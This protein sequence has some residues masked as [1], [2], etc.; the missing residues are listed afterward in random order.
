MR[1]RLQ[2]AIS[3]SLA[4]AF[5]TGCDDPTS[6][7]QVSTIDAAVRATT[8]R[9]LTATPASEARI[10][11][12]WVDEET[13]ETGWET[14]RSSTG[15]SGTF[16]RIASLG[17]NVTAYTD[18]GLTAATDYCYKVRP[19]RS[20]KGKTTYLA[21]SSVVCS[22]TFALPA[23]SSIA[24]VPRSLEEPAW[25]SVI[26]VAW[27]DGSSSEEGFRI[28]RSGAAAGPWTIVA[29]VGANINSYA[30]ST[31]QLEQLTCYRVRAF[32]TTTGESASSPASCTAAPRRP[33]NIVARALDAAS[34][35]VTWSDSSVVEDGYEVERALADGVWSLIAGLA[36]NATSYRDVSV[37]PNVRYWYRV[38]A[39]KDG[40]FSFYSSTANASATSAAPLAPRDLTGQPWESYAEQ[41]FYVFLQWTPQSTDQEGFRLERSPDGN[42]GW[43]L[44]RTTANAGGH[45]PAPIEQLFCYRVI[46]FN[47]LG[48]SPPSNVFCTA[49]TATPTNLTATT[50]ADYSAI[51]LTWQDN[52]A[53]EHG[54][55]VLVM[56]CDSYGENCWY[57]LKATV[58]ANTTSFHDQEIADSESITYVVVTLRDGGTSGPSN[59]ATAWTVPPPA[60]PTD[61]MATAV[62]ATRVDLTW[63]GT[64]DYFFVERCTGTAATC[65]NGTYEGIQWVAVSSFSDP[66]ARASTTY[67]Y[68]VTAS[69]NEQNSAPS[70]PV[71]VT[72]PA[73][74]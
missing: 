4:F 72:T 67:T 58:P 68:R 15:A 9:S 1:S 8:S 30:D 22:T 51:D 61:V 19:Y 42:S 38:R 18:N 45:F 47:G 14:H 3:F 73:S 65:S 36:A 43:Q 35:T 6:P 63:T 40:G 46:A 33:G 62:S 56:H 39:K 49:P 74:Q 13:N 50:T 11:L 70:A 27:T 26:S 25:L 57:S 31:I 52:S 20:A 23:P 53:I 54:Y 64:G 32:K 44:V 29:T 41:L 24:A 12:T 34:I 17:A 21:F 59:P 16:T 48:D 7:T 66:W 5:L 69:R 28:E 2:A 37:T 55:Q 60:A 71:T 10:S